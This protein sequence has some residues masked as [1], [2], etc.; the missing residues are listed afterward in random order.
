MS[1]LFLDELCL[2][3][4]KFDINSNKSNKSNKT[5]NASNFFL[6][7]FIKKVKIVECLQINIQHSTFFCFAVSVSSIRSRLALFHLQ[8]HRFLVYTLLNDQ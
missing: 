7:A 1:Q 5:S 8:T 3:K 6:E 2:G 4:V